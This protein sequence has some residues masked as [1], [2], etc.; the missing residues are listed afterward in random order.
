MPHLE[1]GTIHELLDGELTGAEAA[2]IAS[3]VESCAECAARLGEARLFMAEADRLIAGLDAPMPAAVTG[4]AELVGSALPDLEIPTERTDRRVLMPSPPSRGWRRRTQPLRWAWA[5]ML[6]LVAGGGYLALGRGRSGAAVATDTRETD[7]AR[8]ASAPEAADFATSAAGAA[9]ANVDS[10]RG[11]A[12]E[13]QALAQAAAPA[14]RTDSPAI[15][16]A[17]RSGDLQDRANSAKTAS[18]QAARTQAA[19]DEAARDEAAREQVR[20]EREAREQDARDRGARGTE[21]AAAA[22]PAAPPPPA[23]APAGQ[24]SESSAAGRRMAD[25]AAMQPG[26]VRGQA[27]ESEQ[28][29]RAGDSLLVATAP[30]V[31]IATAPARPSIDLMAQSQ[32]ALRIGLDEAKRELGGNL[33]VID[34]LQPE[35]VG[36]VPGRLVPGADTGAYVVRVVYLDDEQRTIFLD[37]QRI[38]RR[39]GSEGPVAR[40]EARE[41]SGRSQWTAGNVRLSLKGSLPRDSLARLARKVR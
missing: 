35:F 39:P 1:E 24:P 15:A 17:D 14:E 23:P 3:H 5:A 9:D 38:R 19:R 37:Q 40:L 36:L 13:P 26:V 12:A 29:S 6:A 33:H 28:R 2:E 32:I 34:G 10:G 31:P 18:D 22:R 30:S 8:S 20:R 4:A 11:S 7:T 25:V 27:A 21:L 16:E 41:D